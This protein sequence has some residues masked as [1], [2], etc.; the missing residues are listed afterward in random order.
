MAKAEV[1]PSEIDSYRRQLAERDEEIRRLKAVVDSFLSIDVDSGLLNRNGLLEAIKRASLW[2][3]RRRE[4]FGVMAIRMPRLADLDPAAVPDVMARV[5]NALS[6]TGRAVDD[7][8]KVDES[9]FVLVLREF[10]RHGA[11][12]VVSRMRIALRQS[13][14][15]PGLTD[16]IRFG[17]VVAVETGSHQPTDYLQDAL[18]ASLEATPDL[19]RFAE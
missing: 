1:D 3:D 15:N 12:A 16:D 2:W 11:T 6:D 18:N 19:H 17:L 10:H 14:A 7:I 8:G 9:T 13:I 5:A 4:P